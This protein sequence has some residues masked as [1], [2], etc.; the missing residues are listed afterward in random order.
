MTSQGI[1][2]ESNFPDPPAENQITTGS[3]PA[4]SGL[5]G[6]FDPEH[7]YATGTVN[8]CD[9]DNPPE[10]CLHKDGFTGRWLASGRTLHA[11]GGYFTGAALPQLAMILDG[12]ARIDLGGAPNDFQFYGVIDTNGFETFRIEERDGKLGQARY[13]FADDFTFGSV[14]S[15]IFSDGFEAGSTSAWSVTV[16]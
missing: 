4:R 12:G 3:G 11:V 10:H 6:V 9:V 13:V 16:P 5:Y 7:G 2:W 1:I 8:Q 14:L 15:E